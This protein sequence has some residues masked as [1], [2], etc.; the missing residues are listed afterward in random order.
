MD[1]D[2]CVIEAAFAEFQMVKTRE[3]FVMKFELPLARASE[4][5]RRIGTPVPGEEIW[6]AIARLHKQPEQ[7]AAQDTRVVQQCAMLCKNVQFQDWL[8]GNKRFDKLRKY[9]S[10]EAELQCREIVLSWCFIERR[11]DLAHDREAR[12]RWYEI[13]DAFKEER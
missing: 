12:E 9:R 8:I 10:E 13:L 1:K 4:V 11:A 6:C 2:N 3:V 7:P 5:L